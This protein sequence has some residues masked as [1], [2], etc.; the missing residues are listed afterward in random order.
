MAWARLRHAVIAELLAAPPAPGELR[1]AFETQAAKRWPHPVTGEWIT[2]GASSIERWYYAARQAA[3]PVAALVHQVRSDRGRLRAL[4]A[5][6]LL[7]LQQQYQAHPRWSYQLHSDNLAALA[8]EKPELGKPVS[9]ST[10]RRCMVARD[11]RPRRGPRN[12][13]PGQ[14]KAMER[15]EKRET[16]SY[17]KQHVHAL[18]HYDFHQGSRR[19]VDAQGRYH[20][21]W[22]LGILDDCSRLCCH[23]QWYL[24]ETAENLIHGYG[25]A[26]LKRG[27]P[28]ASMHDGG[29]AMRAAETLGGLEWFGIA[30]Q[31]TLPYSPEQNGKQETFWRQVEGRLL[32]MLERVE[33]LTLDF[34][35]RATQAWVE[36]EYNRS[37]HDELG[38]SPIARMAERPTVARPAPA[39]EDLRIA[40]CT[41]VTRTQRRSDGTLSVGGVRFEL[42]G[43]LRTLQKPRV[44]YRRW[45]L[46]VA[47]VICERTRDVLARIRP[48]DKAR[49]ADGRRRTLAPVHPL[50]EPPSADDPPVDSEPLAPLMRQYLAEYAATG[51]PLAYLPKDERRLRSPANLDQENTEDHG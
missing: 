47:Y 4:T 43:H 8:R 29:A 9:Y 37:H 32:P 3:D 16:R 38:T 15:R 41:E 33:P 23:L 5:A 44:R 31:P 10:V 2:F 12:P 35:N 7:A 30:S 21:P 51:L 11:W 24:N 18:W 39:I 13:T 42:P 36:L 48:L 19:V 17:E 45:D 40:F 46:S 6:L 27:L 1:K 34:L 50:P 22:L 26:V 49:N 28:R 25:Q 20:T 14:R